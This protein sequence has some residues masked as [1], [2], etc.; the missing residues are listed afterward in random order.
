M[1]R[2]QLINSVEQSIYWEVNSFPASP[3]T[4][5]DAEGSLPCSQKPAA[6]H[7]P[8]PDVNLVHSL[9]YYPFNIHFNIILLSMSHSDKNVI[10]IF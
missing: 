1:Y 7:C 8:K 5:M 2:S 9:I 4:F 3:E 6:Y 10:K